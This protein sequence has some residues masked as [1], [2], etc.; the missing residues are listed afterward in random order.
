MPSAQLARVFV[1]ADNLD[2]ALLQTFVP[3]LCKAQALEIVH[4]VP[5]NCLAD[6]GEHV[7]VYVEKSTLDL[8]PIIERLH[9]QAEKNHKEKEKLQAMLGNEKFLANAPAELVQKN[10]DLLEKLEIK[11]ARIADELQQLT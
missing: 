1:K 7:A 5:P 8:R 11:L 10:R 2:S 9:K 3:Q 4:D 6:I